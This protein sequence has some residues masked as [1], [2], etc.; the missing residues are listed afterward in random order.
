MV[1]SGYL[2]SLGTREPEFPSSGSQ[3]TG[4]GTRAA[5]AL[6]EDIRPP[7]HSWA[8]GTLDPRVRQRG[9][10]D[11]PEATELTAKQ[12]IKSSSLS[13][14][15]LSVLSLCVSRLSSHGHPGHAG[16]PGLHFS[17]A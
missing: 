13:L 3:S 16:D 4:P 1:F 10:Y 7:S 5:R 12:C 11:L 9:N 14:L 15:Q 17:K 8:Q 2:S 6:A